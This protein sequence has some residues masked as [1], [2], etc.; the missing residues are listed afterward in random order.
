MWLSMI[1][2]NL[3]LQDVILKITPGII[4][5]FFLVGLCTF[6]ARNP[7]ALCKGVPHNTVLW[8]RTAIPK[9]FF[10]QYINWKT[11]LLILLSRYVMLNGTDLELHGKVYLP[12][13]RLVLSGKV[14][15][16]IIIS[17]FIK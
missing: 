13:L 8:R 17:P 1:L 14:I 12:F 7:M 3:R 4:P 16:F 15:F 9:Y 2:G 5:M 6:R 10:Y 11:M